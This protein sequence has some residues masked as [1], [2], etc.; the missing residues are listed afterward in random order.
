MMIPRWLT[1][2][3]DSLSFESSHEGSIRMSLFSESPQ[4]SVLSLYPWQLGLNLAADFGVLL[5]LLAVAVSS[6]FITHALRTALR[7]STQVHE[8]VPCVDGMGSFSGSWV[9]IPHKAFF[10]FTFKASAAG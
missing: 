8:L 6:S 10:N 1:T 4:I 9:R 5:E 7:G 2:L 3:S